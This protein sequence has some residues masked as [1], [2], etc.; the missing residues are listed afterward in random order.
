MR[1]S[2]EGEGVEFR[3]VKYARS[4]G[5]STAELSLKDMLRYV[6]R[7]EDERKRKNS[8]KSSRLER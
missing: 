2:R 4:L 8:R 6:G 3:I 1:C 5:K 7:E